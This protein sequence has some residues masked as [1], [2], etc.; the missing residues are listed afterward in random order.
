M[1]EIQIQTVPPV[2]NATVYAVLFDSRDFV[3]NT[4][5]TALEQ[6]NFANYAH[7]AVSLTET[8]V[9]S[10]YYQGNF[11][12]GI[13][14]AGEYS[15]DIFKQVGGSPADTDT[16][17]AAGTVDWNGTAAI[18]PPTN[19]QLCTVSA[20]SS[21]LNLSANQAS[22]DNG[23]ISTLIGAATTAIQKYTLRDFF[24]TNYSEYYDGTGTRSLKLKQFPVTAIS[25]VTYYPFDITPIAVTGTYFYID[26]NTGIISSIPNLNGTPNLNYVPNWPQGWKSVLVQYTAGFAVIPADVQQC[27]AM[28]SKMLYLQRGTDLLASNIKLGDFQAQ[29]VTKAQAWI[30]G[31]YDIQQVLNRYKDHPL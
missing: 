23:F 26:T 6:F 11:P 30:N 17:I 9:G 3:W 2:T 8:P 24:L 19:N 31:D 7:Y 29:Y 10:G 18:S 15:G 16:I 12:V 20:V 14:I 13:T 28:V 21:L 4:A 25:Q 5:T 1:N 22:I 27:C